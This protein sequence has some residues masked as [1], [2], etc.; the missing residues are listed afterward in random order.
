MIWQ[1]FYDELLANPYA[2]IA[3]SA[4]VVLILAALCVAVIRG[5][6]RRKSSFNTGSRDKQ[7]YVGKNT[8]VKKASKTADN[9]PVA[10]D[11]E[12]A[13][14]PIPKPAPV[15][16]TAAETEP[17]PDSLLP[18][19]LLIARHGWTEE[20]AYLC[21]HEGISSVFLV[22][23][24]INELYPDIRA[25]W[26]RVAEDEKWL[27]QY[28]SRLGN[29]RFDVG[30]AVR[31]WELI[32]DE[33]LF[34]LLV[35]LLAN[36]DDNTRTAAGELLSGI[37]DKRSIPYLVAALMQPQ[38]YVAARVVEILSVF[39]DTAAIVLSRLLPN[40][41][42]QV[43]LVVLDSLSLF[44]PTYPMTPIFDCLNAPREQVRMFAAR[45]LGEN[46]CLE[47]EHILIECLN[48]TS[49]QVRAAVVKSLGQLGLVTSLSA[50]RRL[51]NDEAWCV[52]ANCREA[53]KILSVGG[54]V[55]PTEA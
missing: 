52:R 1:S 18:Q 30:T 2:L 13:L 19:K 54:A 51:E 20:L 42:G 15:K 25:G 10:V 12:P 46:K 48:D 55:M 5:L 26:L 23:P 53:I 4:A 33:T 40:L 50:I 49:W 35:E 22:L 39:G 31:L 14:R 37:R 38:R 16:N 27:K 34:P 36:R 28:F 17:P 24:I 41:S 45:T 21:R 44:K 11:E 8:D 32:P 3:V 29:P 9:N 43:Q 6:S 47:S 7:V